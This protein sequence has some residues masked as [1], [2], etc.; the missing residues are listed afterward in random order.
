[1]LQLKDLKI[2]DKVLMPYYDKRPFQVV[3]IDA[4]DVDQPVEVV[5]EDGS[6]TWAEQ[7]HVC[8][9]TVKL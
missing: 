3:A 7:Q 5:W 8:E 9:Q 6:W 2:G 1:M 4:E